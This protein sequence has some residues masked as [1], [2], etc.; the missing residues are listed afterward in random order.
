MLH[1]FEGFDP[2]PLLDQATPAEAMAAIAARFD[3]LGGADKI[4]LREAVI[5]SLEHFFSNGARAK[6]DWF[7]FLLE[8]PGPRGPEAGVDPPPA[9]G[10]G[11]E[12]RLCDLLLAAIDDM[13]LEE[14][15]ERAA[16]AARAQDI[17]L[18]CALVM[19][20]EHNR[21]AGY[22]GAA[23][24][25]VRK[26]LLDRIGD[27]AATSAFWAQRFPAALLWFWFAH[28]EEQRVYLFTSRAMD[29]PSGLAALLT[30]P[31]ERSGSG[32]EQQDVVAA[33][34][35][36]RI[37]DFRALEARAVKLAMSAPARD[38]RRRARRFLDAF[39]AGKSELFR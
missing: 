26:A 24:P 3:T 19:A 13:P 16:A 12:Q 21:D 5:A 23:S 8:T 11:I 34:R 39:A 27:L 31:L 4:R 28:G 9:D 14:R 37:I 1:D 18:L 15:G 35:W 29:D 10:R 6:R 22:L 2:V 38:D 7:E 36:S 30:L 20:S 17:S 25:R 32:A 33:R